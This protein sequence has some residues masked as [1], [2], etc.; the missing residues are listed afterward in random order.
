MFNK[1]IHCLI[2]IC[3]S[4][5]SYGDMEKT[6]TLVSPQNVSDQILHG[7]TRLL[8]ESH[9]LVILDFWASWCGPCKESLKA[10]NGLQ[11]KYKN[12]VMFIAINEDE[13]KEDAIFFL[14]SMS[15]ENLLVIGDPGQKIAKSVQLQAVPSMI[16]L[17]KNGKV[18]FRKMGF[19]KKSIKSIESKIEQSL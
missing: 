16:I 8:S 1:L 13:K 2:V 9:E 5:I 19:G 10:L 4:S 7:N 3:I 14:K 11:A 18:L 12:K 17:D 6:L 15:L